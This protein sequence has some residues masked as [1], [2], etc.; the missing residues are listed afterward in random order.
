MPFKVTFFSKQQSS[1]LGG[2]S[3]SFW[4]GSTQLQN[5]IEDTTFTR[6]F[7]AQTQGAQAYISE[8]RISEVG[9]FRQVRNLLFKAAGPKKVED[10]NPDADY[11]STAIQLIMKAQP[12]HSAKVW[13]RGI[14]DD[15][16]SDAG[17]YNPTPLFKK[18]L[19]SFVRVLTEPA[20]G[21]SLRVLDPA[22][23]NRPITAFNA[24]TGVVT[25]PAHGF[26]AAGTTLKVRVKGVKG[27]AAAN[28]VWRITVLTADTVQLSFWIETSEV[29][30]PGGNP[31]MTPQTYVFVKTTAAEAGIATSHYT[32]R[33]TGLLGG[34][35]RKRK[36]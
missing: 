33:P 28:Q 16:V 2:W 18:R 25:V 23:P 24:Q 4:H 9:A 29:I 19:D 35:R 1:K 32:G 12:N 20:L 11:P 17:K 6:N 7:L 30:Q 15:I 36:S 26:G 13:L 31:V 27:I 8:A 3:T 10:D 14:P 21:W 34:R 22:R 5:C